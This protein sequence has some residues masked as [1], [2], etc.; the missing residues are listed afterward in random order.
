MAGR[1]FVLCFYGDLSSNDGLGRKML[2]EWIERKTLFSEGRCFI[3]VGYNPKDASDPLLASLPPHMFV[4]FSDTLAAARE[5][6]ICEASGTAMRH[7]YANILLETNLTCAGT[8]LVENATDPNGGA[9]AAVMAWKIDDMALHLRH[10]LA[11][12]LILPNVLEPE[13][14]RTLIEAY[15]SNGGTPSGFMREVNGRTVV[16]VD[17]KHKIRSD[18]LLEEDEMLQALRQRV[19]RRIVPHIERAFQFKVTRIERYIVAC[20]DATE[21]GHFRAHRDNT[22]RGTAHRRFAVSINL[23]SDEYEGGDLQ[24]PEYGQATYRAPTGGA[25]VFSCSLLHRALPV[26]KGRRY[27]FLPFLYDEAAARLRAENERFLGE[28]P[29][30][31]QAQ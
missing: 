15:T 7:R 27:C 13:L 3:A 28:Q 8:H 26:T 24:F 1:Q 23:N 21:G 11:P 20:Y 6:G 10:G 18:Y 12:V 29:S 4:T 5:Y 19:H 17:P 2:Q 30:K 9:L 14:C 22:T 16:A 31:A 25:V